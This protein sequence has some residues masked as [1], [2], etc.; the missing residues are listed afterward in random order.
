[1]LPETTL[2]VQALARAFLVLSAQDPDS[3]DTRTERLA[4]E[5]LLQLIEEPGYAPYAA[6]DR[7]MLVEMIWNLAGWYR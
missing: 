4:C 2:E 5:R 7:D 1:M 6:A 3:P